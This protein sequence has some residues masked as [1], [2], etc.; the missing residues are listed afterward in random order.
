MEQQEASN[1]QD[2]QGMPGLE[3]R[4]ELYAKWGLTGGEAKISTS[5]AN[6]LHM[7]GCLVVL[8]VIQSVIGCV[9]FYLV[10]RDC[11]TNSGQQLKRGQK[12]QVQG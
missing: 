7:M 8:C 9:T 12:V 3:P 10:K 1:N 5:D 2:L 6:A 11:T 4:T